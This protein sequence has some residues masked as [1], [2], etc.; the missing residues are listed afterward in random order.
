MEEKYGIKPSIEHYACV[1]DML[2]RDGRLEEAYEMAENLGEEVNAIQAWG[3]LLA[4]C[5][6]H[7]DHE[8]AKI[9]ANKLL[10]IE[11]RNS[12]SG[13]HVLLSNIYA[14]EGNW[15]VA[16]RVRKEMRE[17][18]QRKEVGRSW[19]EVSGH[20]NYFVSKDLKHQECDH[21]YGMLETLV[22][23][24]EDTDDNPLHYSKMDEIL[25]VEE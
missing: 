19:I 5:R 4:A 25:N 23:D 3:S 13:Y 21:I 7:R 24:M 15:E 16:D 6:T 18:G 12:K 14:D 22:S 17:R 10:D 8:L 1:V 11:S 20:V 9:V 2:G